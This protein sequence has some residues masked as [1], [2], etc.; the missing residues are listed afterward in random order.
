MLDKFSYVQYQKGHKNSKGENAFW[1]IR[2]HKNNKILSS[3]KTKEEAESHLRDM[4]IHGGN[5]V[6][7]KEVSNIDELIKKADTGIMSIDELASDI[8]T[9]TVNLLINELQESDIEINRYEELLDK[10]AEKVME[11]IYPWIRKQKE[12][13]SLMLEDL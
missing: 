3:H 9:K 2:D 6:E 11:R 5:F 13:E 12:K 10:V 7:L 8:A 1:V 4:K